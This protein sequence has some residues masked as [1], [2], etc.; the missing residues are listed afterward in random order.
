MLNSSRVSGSIGPWRAR[1]ALLGTALCLLA[2][3]A[4]VQAQWKWRD[5]AGHVTASDRPPPREVPE[6]DIL[7]RPVVPGG[8]STSPRKPYAAAPEP[9]ASAP[10]AAASAPAPGGGRQ[11]P[12][13]A[14]VE[15]KR[16]AA[17]QEAQ[18]KAKVEEERQAAARAENCKRARQQVATLESGMRVARVNAK[19]E[20]EML[21]DT[22]RA[23]EIKVARAVVAGDCR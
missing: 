12:L 16:R 6:K 2:V 8:N 20:R 23:E 18:A 9:A 5:A 7:A 21:D 17:E 3:A 13:Q 10:V 14:E 15:A 4:P 19:G 22:S 11:S 1:A